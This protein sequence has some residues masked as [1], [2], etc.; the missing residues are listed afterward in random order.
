MKSRRI[1]DFVQSK[2]T[3]S[4]ALA[5]NEGVP[6]LL[7]TMLDLSQLTHIFEFANFEK[8]LPTALKRLQEYHTTLNA[9]I[10]RDLAEYDEAKI[11]TQLVEIALMKANNHEEQVSPYIFTSTTTKTGS[12]MN[13]PFLSDML[14]PDAEKATL[15]DL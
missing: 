4:L 9:L 12:G 3:K 1:H 7:L 8:T 15:E 5:S 2:D 14:K 10:E 13:H 11:N 6:L